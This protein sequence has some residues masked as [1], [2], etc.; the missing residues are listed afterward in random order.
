M[1]LLPGLVIAMYVTG[2]KY[3]P[4]FRQEM[5][6]YLRN[7]ANPEDGGWGVHIEG[8]STVFG[9]A[10]NYA[11]LRILG[12]DAEDPACVKARGTLHKLG[13]ATGI[14]SWGKFWLAVLL[15]RR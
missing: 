3:P 12:L 14:P 2:S 5:I 8:I 7:R 11:A 15:F 10:L 1:F 13:G 9:T 4:G 6:R